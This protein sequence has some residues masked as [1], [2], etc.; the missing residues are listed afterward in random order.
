MRAILSFLLAV[1]TATG[2][3]LPAEAQQEGAAQTESEERQ[4]NDIL[5]ARVNTTLGPAGLIRVPH[6][7]VATRNRVLLGAHLGHD[8]SV[9]GNYGLVRSIDVGASYVETDGGDDD[10]LLN[11]K[12]NIMPGNF[13]HF[14]LGLGIVDLL[15]NL[16]QT[17][18]FMVSWEKVS[19]DWLTKN[20]FL[21]MRLH[22]GFGSG[23][24]SDNIIGGG[25]F[26]LSRRISVIGEFDGSKVNAALRYIPDES[27]RMQVGLEKNGIFFSTTYG[28]TP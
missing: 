6:A 28:F 19:P 22:A 27:L 11:G 16:D 3:I 9:T 18:Y 5:R 1:L 7:Y 10:I 13:K 15:D 12:V 8:D 17:F 26:L 4:T 21:G 25:E 2:L 14:E 23:V 20:R 24:Y